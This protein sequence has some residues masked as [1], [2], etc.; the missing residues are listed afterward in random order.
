MTEAY[1][2]LGG[3]RTWYGQAGQGPPL[4]M[5]HPGGVDSRAFRPNVEALAAHFHLW[6]PERRGHGRTAD[7]DDPYTYEAGADDTIQFLEQI[8]GGPARLLGMSDGALVSLHVA[9]K[10]PDLVERLV[11]AGGVFHTAAWLPGVLVPPDA[12]ASTFE[13]KLYAMHTSSP[14]LTQHDLRRVRCR[15][16]VM[17][18]DDDEMSL[19]HLAE[20][21]RSLPNSELAIVPGTSHGFL[22]EKPHICNALLLDFLTRD[23]VGTFAPIRRA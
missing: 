4:V 9:M 3:V 6:L 15:T 1:V 20:L 8:V 12:G 17:A 13:R 11:F 10:R 19:E 2:D 18:G 7:S 14:R 21:Y 23:P 16:L 5:L 22:V